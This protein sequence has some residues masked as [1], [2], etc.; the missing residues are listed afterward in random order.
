MLGGLFGHRQ[1]DFPG[2]QESAGV[3]TQSRGDSPALF[4]SS[5][6]DRF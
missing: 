2:D 3:P 6:F 4:D 1:T 5:T